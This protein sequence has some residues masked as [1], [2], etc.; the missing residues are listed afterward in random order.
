M[1]EDDR[2]GAA[3]ADE[4][5]GDDPLRIELRPALPG[6]WQPWQVEVRKP[7]RANR[8]NGAIAWLGR[9]ERHSP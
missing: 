9:K 8:W 5:A 3:C 7:P 1:S 4:G 2:T 6:W